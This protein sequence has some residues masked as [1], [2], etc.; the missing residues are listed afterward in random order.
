MELFYSS[1][2]EKFELPAR[3]D[4]VRFVKKHPVQFAYNAKELQISLKPEEPPE[5]GPL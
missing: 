5:E 1:G 2:S 4:F 3:G